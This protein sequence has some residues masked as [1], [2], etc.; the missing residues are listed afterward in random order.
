MEEGKE[1]DGIS[2]KFVE[3]Q[4]TEQGLPLAR[5]VAQNHY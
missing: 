1:H 2:Y 3:A 5:T 4:N